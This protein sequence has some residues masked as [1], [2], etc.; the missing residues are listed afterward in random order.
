MEKYKFLEHT[1]D[2]KFQAFGKTLEEA[3]TNAALATAE[4]MTEDK[5][6]EIETK[7]FT[8]TAKKKETLLYEYLEQLLFWFDTEGFVLSKVKSL[9]IKDNTLTATITGDNAENYEISTHI[10][11]VTYSDMFIKEEENLV[12][13]Q[14]VHDI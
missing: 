10:K 5:I 11:A 14:V 13:V 1:A 8:V 12:T 6:K 9:E 3:F 7:T 4:I 2:V